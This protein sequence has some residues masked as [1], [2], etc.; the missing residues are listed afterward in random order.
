M[1]IND[2]DVIVLD[3]GFY[4]TC[5]VNL[6]GATVVSW[7]ITNREQLFVSRQAIFDKKN[8]IRGGIPIIFPVFGSW[9][10]GPQ[11]G[12]ARI[13]RWNI[14][15]MPERN[16]DNDVEAAFS[17]V[18][19]DFTRSMWN[20][21]FK[22]VYYILLKE[23]EL[24]FKITVENTDRKLPFDFHLLL[25]TYFKVPN[26]HECQIYGLQS[27]KYVDRTNK[28]LTK[29]NDKEVV[30]IENF[31]DHIYRNTPEK[32]TITNT[33]GGR[34][35]SIFKYNF[36][37]TVVWNPWIENSKKLLDFG[38]DEYLRMVCVEVGQVSNPVKLVPGAKF[39]A[40]QI[41]Q[42]FPRIPPDE[43]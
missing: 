18:D 20:Y 10:F 38:D 2:K 1:E 33:V 8:I 3:R 25:H 40:K 32:L 35:M 5:T 36:P 29:E 6:H 7:Q 37:D 14:E 15:K 41:L 26:I 23:R 16:K 4:T 17:L 11:H 30:V 39:E 12:F 13:V 27:C 21:S 31:I 34:S 22:I 28:S 19:D 42:V 43:I 9:S 24:Q